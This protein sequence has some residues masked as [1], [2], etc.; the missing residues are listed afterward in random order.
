MQQCRMPSRIKD[1]ETTGQ[2]RDGDSVGGQ[3]GAVRRAVDAVG[4]TGD[5]RDVA[6]GQTGRQ[7]G[8]DLFAVHR[9]RSGP[10]DGG[11][12]VRHL[13]KTG[14]AQGPQRHRRPAP[15][16]RTC[17]RTREGGEREHRPLVVV[18]GDQSPAAAGK[19]F[20]IVCGPVDLAPG[21]GVS[22]QL[23]VDQSTSDAVGRLH[24]ADTAHQGGEF[25]A[26]R[27]GDPGQVGPRP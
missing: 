11:G 2:H 5:D 10:D 25:R 8:G 20:E 24:R 13:V 9:R 12:A 26:G 19:Q 1:V 6:L 21:L 16:P 23:V 4:A 27:L 22:R 3:C 15:R 14:R 17:S 18:G 7:V